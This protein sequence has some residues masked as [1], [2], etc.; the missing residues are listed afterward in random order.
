MTNTQLE[1]NR[2]PN[3]KQKTLRRKKEN[4]RKKKSEVNRKNVQALKISLQ[5][6]LLRTICTSLCLTQYIVIYPASYL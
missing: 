2:K 3:Q 1:K 4:S 6:Y 5:R